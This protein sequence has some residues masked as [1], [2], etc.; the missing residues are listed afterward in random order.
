MSKFINTIFDKDGIMDEMMEGYSVR[1]SQIKASEIIED[2][3]TDHKKQSLILEAGCGFGKTLTY[4]IPILKDIAEKECK[5]KLVIATA[6]ISLQEQLAFKDV[7]FAI[8][9]IEKMFN[10]TEFTVTLFKGKQNFLC[11]RKMESIIQDSLMTLDKNQDKEIEEIKKWYEEDSCTGD[12]SDLSFVPCN[13]VLKQVTCPDADECL[14]KKCPSYDEC[15][16]TEHKKLLGS[17]NIIITNYSMLY[18]DIKTGGHILPDYDYIVFDEC[19]EAVN[20]CRNFLATKLS[21]N[22]LVKLKSRIVEINNLSNSIFDNPLIFEDLVKNDNFILKYSQLL[23]VLKE[24]LGLNSKTNTIKIFEEIDPSKIPLQILEECIMELKYM[25]DSLGDELNEKITR[26]AY[27]RSISNEGDESVILS[28]IRTKLESLEESI[29]VFL[30]LLT[31]LKHNKE[32]KKD[33]VY[34]VG[35]NGRSEETE[36]CQMP[37]EVSEYMKEN[38]YDKGIKSFFVSAT[39]SVANDFNYFRE[40]IGLNLID[41]S[42]TN[43]FI[44]ES[45]FNMFEQQLWYLPEDAIEGNKKEFNSGLSKQII[46]LILATNGGVLCLFTSHYNMLSSYNTANLEIG[47]M[48]KIL[49]QGDLPKMKLIN[50][51]KEDKNSVLFATK[52]FFTGIDV[53]GD[54]L[55]CLVI[56]KLPF[57]QPT[58]PVQQKLKNENNSFYRFSIPEMIINLKQA[59]GRGVR[60][61]EDKCVI[62]FLDNR[63]ATARYKVRVNSSFNY[64]KN[65]TR[66]L[67]GVNS[68]IKDYIGDFKIENYFFE[69]DEI[70]DYEPF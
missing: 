12:L 10:N 1:E 64:R 6:N 21:F 48:F 2:I 57:P 66:K 60:S 52:S 22:I 49:K 34:W 26:W 39:I 65:V 41:E 38:F 69:K 46:D 23:S 35:I 27:A 17:S 47:H 31:S 4:L 67:E 56:D 25:N 61:K 18:A 45:P 33:V 63:M 32:C 15:F 36:I 44:G 13:D 55:R 3:L 54:S 58:D 5:P 37:V 29:S 40:Q 24:N 50:A 51:F 70:E 19:H 30:N 14:R 62:A 16:H 11:T 20:I 53:R 59:I 68:F 9:V 42:K 43:S 28:K 8:S 7:P